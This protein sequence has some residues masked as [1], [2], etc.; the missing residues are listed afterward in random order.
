MSF[1]RG[2]DEEPARLEMKSKGI[3][4]KTKTKSSGAHC[5]Q[6]IIIHSEAQKREFYIKP[7][8]VLFYP[9]IT[10]RSWISI[11]SASYKLHTC[12]GDWA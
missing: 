1:Q 8:F 9:R 6:I 3:E 2:G 11:G 4:L 5:V 10:I 12:L 7:D